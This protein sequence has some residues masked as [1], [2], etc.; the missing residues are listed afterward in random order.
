M[1]NAPK[2]ATTSPDNGPARVAAASVGEN[3]KVIPINRKMPPARKY[4]D[5]T[6]F[7]VPHG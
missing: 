7:T 4:S 5:P 6:D 1:S 2:P 3:A